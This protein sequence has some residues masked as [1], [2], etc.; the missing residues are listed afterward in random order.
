MTTV[1]VTCQNGHKNP[2]HRHFC[3]EC[4]APLPVSGMATYSGLPQ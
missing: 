2:E 1:M 4:G 3:G